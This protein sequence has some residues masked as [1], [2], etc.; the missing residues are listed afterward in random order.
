MND[1]QPRRRKVRDMKQIS[2]L[3]LILLVVLLVALSACGGEAEP[4][5]LP[6]TNT[7]APT[8]TDAPAP[9]ATP[10]PTETTAPTATATPP[11]P[12][13]TATA[14]TAPDAAAPPLIDEEEAILILAPGNGSRVSSPVVVSG[15]A[16]PTFEQSLAAR[17]V[18]IDGE[19]LVLE[20]GIIAA[21]LGQRG[22]F[23][24]EVPFNVQEEVQAWIQVFAN[25]ARDGGITHL[26]SVAVTLLPEGPAE[27]AEATPQP[28]RIVIDQPAAGDVAEGGTL[29]VSGRALAGFEQTL[30]VELLD[31]SGEVMATE[32]IIVDAPDL[33]QPGTFET[34]LT[35]SI[36][37]PMPARL[38]LRDPSPAFGGDVHLSSVEIRLE[39]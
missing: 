11:P 7:V 23:E 10:E 14:T 5:A 26:S 22:S 28:E 36:D 1:R 9:P 25:S 8:A 24:I 38:Q 29:E 37:A 6:V 3:V 13:A 4:T 39:P 32:P 27:V 19:E 16:D 21:N 34:E 15:E 17:L 12:T 31:A 35:Y 33:G 18:T 20:P 30:I 2:V